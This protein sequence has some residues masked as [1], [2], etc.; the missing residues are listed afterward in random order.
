MPT[1]SSDFKR[2]VVWSTLILGAWLFFALIIIPFFS[3]F[4]GGGAEENLNLFKYTLYGITGLMA[5]LVIIFGKWFRFFFKKM[6]RYVDFIG[7]DPERSVLRDLPFIG[8]VV[9]S[10]WLSVMFGILIF[11]AV[12]LLG[13][14]VQQTGFGDVFPRAEVPLFTE[15]QV[16]PTADLGLSVEPASTAETLLFAVML[17]F[18]FIFGNVIAERYK[19]GKWFNYGWTFFVIPVLGGFIW[20]AQHLLRYGGSDLALFSTFNFG[21]FSALIVVLFM[22]VLLAVVY[23]QINNLLQK[24]AVLFGGDLMFVY[25][26][27]GLLVVLGLFIWLY[28]KRK[29][30]KGVFVGVG[31]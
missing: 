12:G 7:F 20:M 16:S 19:L 3:L 23:H 1:F 14:G 8:R 26:G 30:P 25:V 5:G 27:V 29:E 24:G 13:L 4:A 28:I 18:L 17:G 31:K 10:F 21:F 2:D 9:R 22:N 15:Q 6:G 11:G